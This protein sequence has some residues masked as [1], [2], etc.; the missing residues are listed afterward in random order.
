MGLLVRIGVTECLCREGSGARGARYDKER[1]LRRSAA[2]VQVAGGD[3]AAGLSR[4]WG[5]AAAAAGRRF[6]SARLLPRPPFAG[7]PAF[8]GFAHKRAAP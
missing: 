7:N 1:A 6:S 5:V 8:L 4:E 2:A 3:F